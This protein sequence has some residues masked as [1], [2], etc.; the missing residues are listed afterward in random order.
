VSPFAGEVRL[1][2][3]GVVS[4]VQVYVTAWP[5][6][7]AGSVATTRKVWLPSARPEYPCGLEQAVAAP[8]SSVHWKLAV[9]EAKKL[10]VVVDWFDWPG[11]VE[12][13]V[14]TGGV[15]STVQV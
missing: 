2:L 11:G 5:T 8:P 7:P 6:L 14:V 4:M 13:R 15:V 10:K 3:G 12:T 9:S 1:M